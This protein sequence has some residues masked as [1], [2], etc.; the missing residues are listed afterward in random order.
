MTPL[1]KCAW[2]E[3]RLSAYIDDEVCEEVGLR[4]KE[5]CEQC[6]SCRDRVSQY[7][8]LGSLMRQSE[9]SVDTDTVWNK[10]APYLNHCDVMPVDAKWSGKNWSFAV[11]ATAASVALLWFAATNH[12][13]IEHGSE[14]SHDH[15]SLAVDFQEVVEHANSEPQAAIAKLVTRYQGQELDQHATSKYLGYEPAIFQSVP[16]GFARISTHVLNMP[17]C[18]CSAT[19]CQRDNGSTLIVFEH[20]DE[21]PVWFG[22]WPSIETQCSGTTCKIIESAGQLAVTWENRDRQLTIIGANDISEINQWVASLTF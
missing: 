13:V 17:C 11:L 12:H 5:H 4:I 1:D 22:D 15:S 8:A 3:E 2:A 9:L 19:I 16:P 6:E 14:R 18:K 10:V 7:L 20:K 21:Q